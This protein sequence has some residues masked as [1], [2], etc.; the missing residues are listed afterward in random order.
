MS[1]VSQAAGVGSSSAGLALNAT[2]IVRR[3]TATKM[4]S[5]AHAEITQVVG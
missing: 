5:A 1:A 2:H 4:P 3:Y